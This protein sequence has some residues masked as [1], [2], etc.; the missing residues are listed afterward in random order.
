M[1]AMM[2]EM[3]AADAKLTELVTAMNQAT[4][5]AKVDATAAVIAAL[6]EHHQTMCAPMMAA[7]HPK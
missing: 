3:K 4:G 5:A 6:V 7:M 1:T 2:A